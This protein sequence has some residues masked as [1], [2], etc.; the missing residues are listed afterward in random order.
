MICNY[1]IIYIFWEVAYL[2]NVFWLVAA[3]FHIKTDIF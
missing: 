1:N 3:W 2:F